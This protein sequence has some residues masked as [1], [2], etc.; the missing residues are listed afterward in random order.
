M[1]QG[2][3]QYG[4]LCSSSARVPMCRCTVDFLILVHFPDCACRSGEVPATTAGATA[5]CWHSAG[6]LG[7]RWQLAAGN[8]QPATGQHIIHRQPYHVPGMA[9]LLI[10][11]CTVLVIYKV[12]YIVRST[13]AVFFLLFTGWAGDGRRWPVASGL[14]TQHRRRSTSRTSY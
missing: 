6:V 5:G 10:T 1:V 7:A 11:Y 3:V 2:T 13:E 4:V 12:L 8:R 14:E 9:N